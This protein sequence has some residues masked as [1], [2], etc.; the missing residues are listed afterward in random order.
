[1][2][3]VIGERAIATPRM[4]LGNVGWN[5]RGAPSHLR[6]ELETFVLGQRAGQLVA[7]DGQVHCR[8]PYVEVPK[9]PNRAIMPSCSFCT[10][11][12]AAEYAVSANRHR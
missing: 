8:L 2:R 3:H 10:A 6:G 11:S 9:V 7:A 5:R 12:T 1:M 4:A